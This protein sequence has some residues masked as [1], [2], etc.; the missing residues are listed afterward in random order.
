VSELDKDADEGCPPNKIYCEHGRMS[1][2]CT[3]CE[4]AAELDLLRRQVDVL[5]RLV[6]SESPNVGGHRG[7][8][9]C[10]GCLGVGDCKD[11]NVCMRRLR[12]WSQEQA[13]GGGGERVHPAP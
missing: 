8:P 11:E 1:C 13:K 2:A 10:Y 12:E 3:M 5:V 7:Q 9:Q 4:I 6:I